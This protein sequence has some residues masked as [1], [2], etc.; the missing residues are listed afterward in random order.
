MKELLA[1]QSGLKAHKGQRNN[2]GKYNY[3]SC[4]D[5]LEA[6]KPLLKEN[7]SI[8]KLTDD[9]VQVGDRI[10]VKATAIIKYEGGQESV[11]AFA[12]EPLSQKGM[13]DCQITGSASSYARKYALN[14]LFAI[15]D[16]EDD[17]TRDNTVNN[18]KPSPKPKIEVIT[19]EQVLTLVKL[20]AEAKT[21]MKA[22]LDNLNWGISKLEQIQVASYDNVV[23]VLEDKIKRQKAK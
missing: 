9:I 3:R 16:T 19:Q 8:L 20:I 21:T 2:F 13:S 1:I 14:G 17:D 4:E 5:I 23:K 12:R 6:V 10:Y 22:L 7:N 15:D 11:S 18:N